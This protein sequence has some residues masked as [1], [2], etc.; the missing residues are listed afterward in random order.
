ME[1]IL[2]LFTGALLLLTFHAA[3]S[4]EIFPQIYFQDNADQKNISAYS[5][6]ERFRYEMLSGKNLSGTEAAELRREAVRYQKERSISSGA[7]LRKGKS[8]SWMPA[9][10]GNTG[11]RIRAIVV[12]PSNINEIVIGSA[13]GGIWKSTDGGASWSPKTDDQAQPAIGCMVLSGSSTL[14][15]GSG[16]GWGETDAVY[17]GGIY[18]STD[19]GN[20]WTLLPSTSGSEAD[21]FRNV[22]KMAV[23]PSGN[24]YALTKDYR[25]QGGLGTYGNSGGLYRSSNGGSTWTKIST[26]DISNDAN[27]CDL[28]PVSSSVLVYAVNAINGIPGGIYR[29]TNS[30]STWTKITSTP[31]PT[32]GYRRI[33]MAQ[34]PNNSL[35]V[36]AVFEDPGNTGL[37]GIY[38]TTNGGVSWTALRKPPLLPSTDFK[39]YLMLQGW[40]SNVIAVDPANSKHILAGGVEIIR[41]TDGG[42]TSWRQITYR[43][44]DDGVPVVHQGH[45]AIVFIPGHPGLIFDCNDG[46]IYKSTDNGDTWTAL[47]NGLEITQF[48]SGAVSY[49]GSTFY[50]GTQDVGLLKFGSG[51]RWDQLINGDFG[52]TAIDQNNSSIVYSIKPYLD[53][54][55]S[56]DGGSNWNSAIA[57]LSDAAIESQCLYISPFTMDP[58]NSNVLIAGSRKIWLS[59]NGA[60]SWQACSATLSQEGTVSA[61]AV[62]NTSAPYIALAGTTDGKIFRCTSLSASGTNVWTE[63]TPPGSNGAWVRRLV[64]DLKDKQSIY[65]CYSGYNNL[66][67][68]CSRH[69]WYSSNQGTTWLDISG[70]GQSAL[71]NVPVH[72]LVIDPVNSSTLYIGTETGIYTSEDRGMSWSTYSSGMPPYV[73]VYDLVLQAGTQKMLAFTH[74]RSVWAGESPLPV[75]LTDFKAVIKE[76]RVELSWITQSEINNYGFEVERAICTKATGD[77]DTKWETIGFVK[78]YGN[79]NSVKDYTFTDYDLCLKGIYKYRLKQSDTDGQ[80][81]YWTEAEVT[82]AGPKGWH[83]GQNF[84]NPFNPATTVKYALPNESRVIIKVYNT[85]GQLIS[86]LANRVQ[87]A[88]YYS[89]S[90]DAGDSPSG[91]YLL[92]IEAFVPGS[93]E[94]YRSA[95]KMLLVK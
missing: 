7:S 17:G 39:S 69:V 10:P 50:G 4:A 95:R 64:F 9:G 87:Q 70:S 75:E 93:N 89:V 74:G 29:S 53:I 14:Y 1:K 26:S 48:Y 47:N 76:D 27:P 44:W 15:A 82:F 38:K 86:E 41:S 45:H 34:D 81:K 90:W 23:D 77:I 92:T 24:I 3:F 28:I 31:L 46:G 20:S 57:G 59:E 8:Q 94:V 2:S 5:K 66:G 72:T 32:S 88:G 42:A 13:A 91:V 49:S 85:N 21:K 33:A 36:Y 25:S 80:I 68:P 62:A 55:K 35:Y 6:V 37:N 19:F 58:E 43:D 54:Y 11:G 12:N 18:K 60:A 73:P 67:T 22:L 52:Y 79:S 78:G 40:H 30:G 51:K 61:A 84:P 71:P 56:T 83:V 16:E 65:A 63:I